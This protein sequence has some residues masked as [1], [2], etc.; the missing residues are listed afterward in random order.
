MSEWWAYENLT[1]IEE[2]GRTDWSPAGRGEREW[3][4]VDFHL[5][6]GCGRVPKARLGIDL[7]PSPGATD[8]AIDLETLLPSPGKAEY[9]PEQ[10]TIVARTHKTYRDRGK[11]EDGAPFSAGLPFPDNSIESIVSH[12]ALE[13]IGPGLEYLMEEC[14]RVLKPGAIFRIIVPLF[15]SYSAVSEYDHKRF[16]MEGTF[17][18]FCQEPD[19]SYTDGF[20]ERY[21]RCC[22][23]QLDEDRSPRTDPMKAWTPEDAREMRVTLLKPERNP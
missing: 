8:L 2:T 16:F 23:R 21:N 3:D 7:R 5:D 20:S 6:L 14:Y 19:Q 13:H 12:H 1:S 15:P 22:F 18:G 9:T 17:M 10:M 4:Q 11:G